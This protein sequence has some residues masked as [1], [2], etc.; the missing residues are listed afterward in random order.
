[1]SQRCCTPVMSLRSGGSRK[2]GTAASPI[3]ALQEPV[4]AVPQRPA[5]SASRC[6]LRSRGRASTPSAKRCTDVPVV[7]TAARAY[8]H[9]KSVPPRIGA[10][11]APGKPLKRFGYMQSPKVVEE[12][13]DA[14]DDEAFMW[15]TLW[16]QGV[17]WS[18]TKKIPKWDFCRVT[19]PWA[20][21]MSS[22]SVRNY[23]QWGPD[24]P[25]WTLE[26]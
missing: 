14:E 2:A 7:L 19:G 26:D 1:L 11:Q 25:L 8:E 18:K 9:L 10:W 22:G 20:N 24:G 15:Q 6:S 17:M 13:K 12:A 3:M 5:S 4:D 21:R 16:P 23:R